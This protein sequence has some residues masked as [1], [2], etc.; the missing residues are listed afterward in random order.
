MMNMD[1]VDLKIIDILKENS[2]LSFKEI[3]V[4]I[5]MTGQAVGTRINRLIEE[6]IIEGFTIKTNKD[7]LGLPVTA[8]IKIYMK[9]LDHQKLFHFIQSTAAIVEAYKTSADCC[10]F[11][12]VEVADNEELNNILDKIN[13]FANYQVTLSI[14]KIK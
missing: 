3:G 6:G 14:K 1:E 4:K 13:E 12:K 2:K 8:L 5:P 10:Y 7:K 9:I 11:A